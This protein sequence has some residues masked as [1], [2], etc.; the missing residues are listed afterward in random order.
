M[1]RRESLIALC[2]PAIIPLPCLMRLAKPRYYTCFGFI[3][4]GGIGRFRIS[5]S[6]YDILN[7]PIINTPLFPAIQLARWNSPATLDM[8]IITKANATPNSLFHTLGHDY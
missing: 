8:P 5:E 1:N 2:L 3:N 6:V 7:L 4:D